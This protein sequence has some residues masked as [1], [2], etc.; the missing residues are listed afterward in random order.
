MVKKCLL[1]KFGI[2]NVD[3]YVEYR[4]HLNPSYIY[5]YTLIMTGTR[6]QKRM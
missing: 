3:K 6:F 1:L 4:I 2:I 5:M